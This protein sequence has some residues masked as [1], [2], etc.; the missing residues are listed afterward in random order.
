MKKVI[1][2]LTC[3]VVCSFLTLSCSKTKLQ[4]GT[5]SNFSKSEVY[6]FRKDAKLLALVEFDKKNV[7]NARDYGS[8]DMGKIR[9]IYELSPASN[10]RAAFSL[11]NDEEK[12]AYWDNI[13]TFKIDNSTQLTSDQKT[14]LSD[15]RDIVVRRIIFQ[16]GTDS[17]T[18]RMNLEASLPLAVSQITN[19]GVPMD[20]FVNIFLASG[21]GGFELMPYDNQN[22]GGNLIDCSCMRGSVIN[23]W[24]HRYCGDPCT[25]KNGGCGFLWAFRCDGRPYGQGPG[26]THDYYDE[27]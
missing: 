10:R 15:Y 17:E 1:K 7:A 21:L 12:F 18:A 27:L 20:E 22:G 11:L 19:S 16:E 14:L 6:D 4:P 25:V 3:A 8:V 24:K 2:T 13:I 26:G 5:D 9:A 23:S